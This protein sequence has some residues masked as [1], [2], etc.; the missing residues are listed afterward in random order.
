MPGNNEPYGT[1][2]QGR[3]HV[4]AEVDRTQPW[5]QAH[6]AIHSSVIGRLVQKNEDKAAAPPVK[7]RADSCL[8][9][10]VIKLSRWTTSAAWAHCAAS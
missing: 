7:L 1:R 5:N 4:R 9:N 6:R 3:A 8:P 10:P 2:R